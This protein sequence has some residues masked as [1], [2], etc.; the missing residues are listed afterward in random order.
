MFQVHSAYLRNDGSVPSSGDT[1]SS[2]ILDIN[3]VKPGDYSFPLVAGAMIFKEG[4]FKRFHKKI[5]AEALVLF[6]TK[7]QEE[8][9]NIAETE[10]ENFSA[11]TSGFHEGK[12]YILRNKDLHFFIDAGEL[13]NPGSG[14][15]IDIFNFELFYKNNSIIVDPGTYSY[16]ADTELRNKLRSDLSH[17][18]FCIDDEPVAYTEGLFK[19]KG[20][21]TKP[22]ILEWESSNAEDILVAQ[23][24]AYARL[25]DPVICKR[26]FHFFKEKNLIKIKDEFFGGKKHKAVFNITFHPE[27]DLIRYDVNEYTA[28]RNDAVIKIRFHSSAE[29]FFSSVQDAVYSGRY[30]CLA[31]TKKI[32]TVSEEKFPAFMITDI[33]LL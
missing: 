9:D 5:T 2:R 7:A 23:H 25:A 19:I 6:G 32:Y 24:Y 28:A 22:K 31:K 26:T 29:Y 8:Y 27:T 17:N 33:E 13:G 16:Y 12:H 10:G 18:I 3:S 4:Q 21:L 11:G 14:A 15:H 30:G 20:D 1:E